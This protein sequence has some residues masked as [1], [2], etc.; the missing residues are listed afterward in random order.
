MASVANTAAKLPLT[1]AVESGVLLDVIQPLVQAHPA[2]ARDDVVIEYLDS[3]DVDPSTIK[4]DMLADILVEAGAVGGNG[5]TPTV[6]V[7]ALCRLKFHDHAL[8]AIKLR[9]QLKIAVNDKYKGKEAREYVQENIEAGS[10][11]DA[12]AWEMIATLLQ[13]RKGEKGQHDLDDADSNAEK[14]RAKRVKVLFGLCTRGLCDDAFSDFA[15][16]TAELK[17]EVVKQVDP[18]TGRTALHYAALAGHA[19]MCRELVAADPEGA[20][21][22]DSDGKLP[23]AI[24]VEHEAKPAAIAVLLEAYPQGCTNDDVLA[25]IER[26]GSNGASRCP[27]RRA[28]VRV[29]LTSPTPRPR[30][31]RGLHFRRAR[32]EDGSRRYL[33]PPQVLD[34]RGEGGPRRRVPC[35]S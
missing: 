1:V 5:G 7:A 22:V 25:Y 4:G 14:A 19:A 11:D 29:S 24:A 6:S 27:R 26:I 8:D 2:G 16:M 28:F 20:E 18:A 9:K 30:R 12:E 3:L 17:T 21:A 35:Q 32:R 10:E 15:D 13:G 33:L 34:E 23:I 31:P